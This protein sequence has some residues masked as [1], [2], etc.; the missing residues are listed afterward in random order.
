MGTQ[1][2]KHKLLQSEE[3]KALKLFI[4][5]FY[6]FLIGYDVFYHF[7]F[8]HF[9]QIEVGF[10]SNSLGIWYHIIFIGFLP[11]TIYLAK[12]NQIYA[13]KYVY[14]FGFIFVDLINNI[15][16]YYDTTDAFFSG[17]AVELVFILFSPLFI[18]NRFFWSAFFGIIGKYALLGIVLQDTVVLLG[19]V[20]YGILAV[21]SYILLSRFE[22][23][24][25]SRLKMNNE[26]RHAEHLASIG[27]FAS[28]ITHE[29]RN[30]LASLKGLTQL[31][32]EKHP[33]DRKYYD[34]MTNEIDRIDAILDDLLIIG[35][36]KVMEFE[37]YDIE[38]L[39][40]YV[41]KVMDYNQFKQEITITKKIDN[42]IPIIQCDAQ[43][44]TQVFI[45]LIKNG[46]E[47]MQ[48]GGN[49]FIDVERRDNQIEI[50]IKDEGCGI[51][52]KNL[53]S[54][55]KEFHTTKTNGTGLGLMVSFKIIHDHNGRIYYESEEG[56]GT[57]VSIELPINQ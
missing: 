18:N 40:D 35:K 32:Q 28:A 30:P 51:S 43:K 6:L 21:I 57:T 52:N 13:V 10:P 5:L 42:N 23:N 46:M 37:E 9:N 1:M 49:I 20:L 25:S 54:L 31:Q 3:V 7:I 33:Q 45:N 4:L 12:I 27:R 22:S 14:L 17:S 53:Q 48:S 41:I 36:P 39:I 19:I 47:S 38:E 55:G 2:K 11:V 56:K 8:N 29:V 15:L 34:I 24:L 44:L 16:I 26:L 50:S